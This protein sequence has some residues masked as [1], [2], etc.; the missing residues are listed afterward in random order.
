MVDGIAGIDILAA[1]L[2]LDPGT[3]MPPKHPW[4]PQPQP[5]ARRLL[6]DEIWRR[7]SLPFDMACALPRALSRPIE[8]AS[9]VRESVLSVSET[10]A[11]GFSGTTDTP[12]NADIGPYRRYDWT[13]FE[14]A[15]AR[16]LGKAAGGTLNDVVL[17][18]VAGAVRRFLGWRGLRVTRDS[19]FRVMVP[20]SIR[21][22]EERGMP[23]NR[24]VNFLAP[25]PIGE[26]SPM[27]RLQR[28]IE[29]T[30]RL[31]HSRVAHGAELIEE[32][33]DRVATELIVQ[34]VRFAARQRAYNLVV[35]NVPGPPC[36]LYLLGAKMVEIY[37]LVPLFGGQALGI[38][39]FSYDGGLHW[40]L[41][42]DWEAMPDLHDLVG[43][44]E[45][46]FA[47]LRTL[48]PSAPTSGAGGAT[49]SGRR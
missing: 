4:I 2:R 41:N 36:P 13:R 12:L 28:T 49:G 11:A 8:V 48:A 19:V 32:I 27:R 23:G 16:A 42:A 5:S 38:A 45:E 30:A 37:P 22:S 44:V 15:E 47:E 35:T 7:A 14:I 40:G 33:G 3:T 21:G 1:I 10:V 31:K 39:L 18:T 26:S 9:S 17:A 20:V 24:V 29:V 34:F 46:E 25:I 43:A 6:G